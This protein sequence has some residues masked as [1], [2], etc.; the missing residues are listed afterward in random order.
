MLPGNAPSLIHGEHVGYVRVVF[1]LAAKV[2]C[3]PTQL[4]SLRIG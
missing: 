4:F 2:L 3:K 1:G